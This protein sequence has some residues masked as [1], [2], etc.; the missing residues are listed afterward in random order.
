MLELIGLLIK[1][2]L[3]VKYAERSSSSGVER[4]SGILTNCRDW[5]SPDFMNLIHETTVELGAISSRDWSAHHVLW[6]IPSCQ[7]IWH[8]YYNDRVTAL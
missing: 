1:S 8:E 6:G 2:S 5:G 4:T 3:E 7:V